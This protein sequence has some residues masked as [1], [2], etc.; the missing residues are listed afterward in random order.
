MIKKI[1]KDNTLNSYGS[2]MYSRRNIGNHLVV[3]RLFI[4]LTFLGTAVLFEKSQNEPMASLNQSFPSQ[5]IDP[6]KTLLVPFFF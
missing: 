3:Q 5:F 4:I 6:F 2:K 1:S